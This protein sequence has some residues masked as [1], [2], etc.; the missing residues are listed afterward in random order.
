MPKMP[1]PGMGGGGG[2]QSIGLVAQFGGMGLFSL[3]GLTPWTVGHCLF[4]LLAAMLGGALARFFF[5]GP[6]GTHEKRTADA[7]PAVPASRAE[8][9]RPVIV[10]WSVLALA[11]ALTFLGLRMAPGLWA[12]GLFLSAW[13]LVGLAVLS[14]IF[15]RGRLRAA[16][17]GA[18]LFGAGYLTLVLSPD[19]AELTAPEHAVHLILN[20]VRTRLPAAL[21][22]FPA[23]SRSVAAANARIRQALE[24]TV[25][26]SFPSETPLEDFLKYVQD[27]A[28]LSDGSRL[29]IYINPVGLNEAEKTMTSPIAIDLKGVPLKTTLGLALQQLGLVYSVREGVLLITAE[30]SD[31]PFPGASAY[32]DPFLLAGHSLLALFAAG[33]GSLLAPFVAY[34]TAT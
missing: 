3:D 32:D 2:F 20:D 29:P 11:A 6:A 33:L 13:V 19:V 28:P 34:R 30:S 12:G 1:M 23:S 9:L 5:G 25:P 26:V 16:W 8:W 17:L 14:A 15:S 18:A 27:H 22:E 4:S 7:E 10:C 24:Q 21:T 31:Q